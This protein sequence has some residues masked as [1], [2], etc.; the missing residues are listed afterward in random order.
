MFSTFTHL[1]LSK[2][3]SFAFAFSTVLIVF[4]GLVSII[5][6]QILTKQT[7]RL[8]I[9][10]L[11]P[12]EQINE[13]STNFLMARVYLRDALYHAQRADVESMKQFQGKSLDY[14]AKADAAAQVFYASLHTDEER[15]MYKEYQQSW[16]AFV[17]IA[18]HIA[19][20]TQQN[21]LDQAVNE[22]ITLCIPAAEKVN[23]LVV[24]QLLLK[25]RLGEEMRS[26]N[27]II[28]TIVFISSVVMVFAGV[29]LGVVLN[30]KL[31]NIISTPIIEL[32][33]AAVSLAEGQISHVLVVQSNDEI[34]TLQHSFNVMAEK[35]QKGIEQLEHEKALV[36]Q[37]I[38]QIEQERLYLARNVE[39]MLASVDKFAHGILTEE[40]HPEKE[41]EIARLYK[42]YNSAMEK[43]R[44]VIAQVVSVVG[45]TVSATRQIV[46]GTEQISAGILDQASRTAT[47]AA[48]TEEMAVSVADN[49]VNI[50]HVANEADA[51]TQEMRRGDEEMGDTIR[52]MSQIAT[53]VEDSALN[54]GELGKSSEQISEVIRVIAEIADQTNL[55]A[56]NAAIEA[57]RAGEQGRGFAVVADEVRKL[58]ERTQQ[59]TKEITNTIQKIQTDTSNAVSAMHRGTKEVELGKTAILQTAERFKTIMSRAQS[60]SDT[61][62][63]VA[64][65]SEE[66]SRTSK[67]IAENIDN[68]SV[69]AG[70]S[71]KAT[72]NIEETARNLHSITEHLERMVRQFVIDDTNNEDHRFSTNLNR[73]VPSKMYL[74]Q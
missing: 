51:M 63:V 17:E 62:R 9:N 2:K 56:L 52:R 20:L 47:A 55:L 21:H 37:A 34:G 59:A 11:K 41:D 45:E 72:K 6:T 53:V 36:L 69:I 18:K 13:I 49:S 73:T 4:I 46:S 5:A 23:N 26:S 67:S 40:L 64:V 60:V 39:I 42:G 27:E 48:A 3:L 16:S 58:A 61:I 71:A 44:L 29:L 70:E 57:A 38:Q 54:I 14:L 15:Q 7:D 32:E 35:I 10:D 31:T 28:A 25:K 30:R 19:L 65:A 33:K 66:Q 43:I 50:L 74:V 12:L 24:G 1:R 8:Y 68:V 22:L